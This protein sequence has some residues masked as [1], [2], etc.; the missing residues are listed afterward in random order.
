MIK[1]LL[2]ILSLSLIPALAPASVSAADIFNKNVCERGKAAD[3]TVCKDKSLDKDE[4][5]LFGPEGVLTR[6]TTILS[7]I[8]GIA[9]VIAIIL[10]GLKYITSSTNPQDLSVARERI[11]YALVALV[12]AASAQ[13]LVRFVLGN[14]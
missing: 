6:V 2:L 4:N 11:I 3:S 10:A 7:V 5:P 14:V 13:L 12:V 9:A 8:V 1:K